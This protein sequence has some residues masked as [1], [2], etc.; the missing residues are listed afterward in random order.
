MKLK[1]EQRE[2]L[3]AGI[4]GAYPNEDDLEIILL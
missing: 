4:M 3:R 1:S 2:I